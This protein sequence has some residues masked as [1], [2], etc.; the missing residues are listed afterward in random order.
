MKFSIY[1]NRR[2]FV[3]EKK[4]DKVS[5]PNTKAAP[6]CSYLTLWQLLHHCVVIYHSVY[7]SLFLSMHY[8]NTPIQ[9]YRKYHLK[10]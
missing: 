9:I 5:R 4:I 3:M 7:S 6:C 1:L 2:V 8:E 10:N